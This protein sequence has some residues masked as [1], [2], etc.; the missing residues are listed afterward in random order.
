MG[1]VKVA[2]N[3][4]WYVLAGR[5]TRDAG[6]TWEYDLWLNDEPTCTDDFCLVPATNIEYDDLSSVFGEYTN[7]SNASSID[8]YV[9]LPEVK[10]AI[11]LLKTA[12]Y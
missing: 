9:Q 6:K 12:K 11:E 5:T 10:A 2:Q 7:K 4:T 1:E 8:Q 3:K